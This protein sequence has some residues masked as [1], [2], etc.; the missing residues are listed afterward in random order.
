[1]THLVKP[2]TLPLVAWQEDAMN[3]PLRNTPTTGQSLIR[4]RTLWT[5]WIGVGQANSK[6][7]SPARAVPWVVPIQATP[8][9]HN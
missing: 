8:G 2:L 5:L 6:N 3:N 1:M 9:L 4:D 7:P